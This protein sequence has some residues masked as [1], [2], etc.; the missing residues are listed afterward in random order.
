[1]F[2]LQPKS[3]GMMSTLV[4]SMSFI[5][6]SSIRYPNNYLII[7]T[8]DANPKNSVIIVK[9]SLRKFVVLLDINVSKNPKS[10][11]H[12]VQ[13][14]FR[15]IALSGSGRSLL[16]S[17]SDKTTNS[18]KTSSLQKPLLFFVEFLGLAAVCWLLSYISNFCIIHLYFDIPLYNY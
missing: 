1:M 14:S 15:V 17:L 9:G 10:P 18:S 8:Y 11:D 16:D 5:D 2:I 6:L 4:C 7:F 13:V 12:F 3:M